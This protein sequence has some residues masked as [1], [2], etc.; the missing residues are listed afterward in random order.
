MSKSI[1]S[2]EKEFKESERI[3]IQLEEKLKHARKEYETVIKELKEL[4]INS[5]DDL[6]KMEEELEQMKKEIENLLPTDAIAEY[7]KLEENL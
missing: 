4:G 2:L 3:S 7:K 5:E 6:K 1:E